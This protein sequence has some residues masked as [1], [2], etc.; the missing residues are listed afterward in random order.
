MLF[1][2]VIVGGGPGGYVAAIKAAQT[3]LKTCLIEKAALGGT[4]L[5]AGCIPTKALLKSVEIMNE[6]KQ[7]DVYGITGIEA[8]DARLD[9]NKV[10]SRK[11]DIVTQMVTGIGVLL[12][13]YGVTVVEGKAVFVDKNRLQVGSETIE[14]KNII[15]ATGSSAKR[16]PIDTDDSVPIYTSTEVLDMTEPPASIAIIGAGVIGVELAYFL[17]NIGVKVNIVELLDRMVPMVDKEI[18]G[19]VENQFAEMGIE[20][21]T[22]AMVK[23]IEKGKLVFEK[24]GN[25]SAIEC[26]A[27]LMATGRK[28]NTE[29]LN[30]EALNIQMDRG[31]IVTDA[32]MTTNIQGIYAIGDVNGK[33]MLA[34][35]AS[36]EGIVAVENIN[37]GTAVMDYDRIPSVIY[38]K[39]EVAAIGLTEEQAKQKYGSIKVG[40]F[41]LFANGKSKIEGEERGFIKVITE[42]HYGEIVGVHMYSLH[43]SDMIAEMSVAMSLECTADELIKAVHPHPT[44]S[45]AIHEACHGAVS[46]AIHF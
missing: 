9:L 42:A 45:E 5:N 19:M 35:T 24:A 14:G 25:L 34:H 36:M 40:K 32:R 18:A 44:I 11:N 4:C 46:K 21:H 33:S 31:A 38:I 17:A 28:P 26:D 41:P 29:G 30:L 7:A 23:R 22:G 1:D 39:P 13:K 8:E 15:I 27:V 20:I 3:G 12:K 10:Q 37:G 2:L 16:V 6:I 43:A